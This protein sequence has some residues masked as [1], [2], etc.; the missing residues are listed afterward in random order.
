[1][2]ALQLK[3]LGPRFT[4]TPRCYSEES[5]HAAVRDA[6]E[7]LVGWAGYVP[8]PP[9]EW[10][11]TFWLHDEGKLQK[12]EP[13]E[14]EREGDRFFFLRLPGDAVR[15]FRQHQSGVVEWVN[16]IPGGDPE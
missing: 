6:P 8:S 4:R 11:F 14:V 7:V 16:S 12:I 2:A 5:Y 9:R 3:R 13:R 15:R 10:T 1:M